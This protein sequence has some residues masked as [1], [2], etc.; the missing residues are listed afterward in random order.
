M[1]RSIDP[2]EPTNATPSSSEAGRPVWRYEQEAIT[3]LDLSSAGIET[4]VWATGYT[5]DFSWIGLPI[6]DHY[7]HPEQ[8]QG[9]TNSPNLYFLGL[10]W[11]HSLKSGLFLGVA[12]DATHVAAH[13]AWRRMVGEA[14]GV[15]T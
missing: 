9:A 7:G 13:L 5:R 8:R 11:L 3:E 2:W 10:H 1:W 15:R 14:A 6:F 4:I 12:E